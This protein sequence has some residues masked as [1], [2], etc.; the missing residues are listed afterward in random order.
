MAKKTSESETDYLESVLSANTFDDESE[1]LKNLRAARERVETTLRA[2]LGADPAIRYGGSHAKCTMVATSYDLDLL[3]YFPRDANDAG[4]TLESL[5]DSVKSALGKT[6]V[7]EAKRS[8]LCIF[9][10]KAYLHID[11]VPGRFVDETKTDVFLHQN[12]GSKDRLKTN[13]E[14][15][16]AHVRDSKVRPAIKL[17]KI[18]RDR[19]GVRAKTFVLELLV[20]KILEGREHE[21]LDVQLRSVF[22]AFRDESQTLSV[23]DPANGENDLKPI[24]DAARDELQRAASSA[25]AVVDAQGWEAVFGKLPDPSSATSTP[26]KAQR[27]SSLAADDRARVRPWAR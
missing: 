16:V 21:P 8:A 17:S 11:V 27:I 14:K 12:D 26:S 3:C 9:D 10:G 2:E 4:G 7:V 19:H 13:P 1:E 22:E 25:L 15:Q 23:S 6:Y 5:W 20:I 24:L 18:W